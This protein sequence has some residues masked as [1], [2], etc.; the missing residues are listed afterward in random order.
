MQGKN[1]P[2][3]S[4]RPAPGKPAAPAKGGKQVAKTGKTPKR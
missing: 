2:Q 1:K 3:S 4:A